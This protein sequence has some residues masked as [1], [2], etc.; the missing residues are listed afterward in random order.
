[1]ITILR[2]EGWILNPN[3]KIVNN[4]LKMIENNDGHCPCYNDSK[5]TKCPCTSYRENDVCHC[6]LYKKVIK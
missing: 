3:D 5:D 6:G 2:K 4:I 1:M